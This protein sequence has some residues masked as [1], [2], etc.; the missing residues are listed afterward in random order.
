MQLS[1]LAASVV[2]TVTTVA[3]IASPASG[4][5]RADV[6]G[7][8]VATITDH[9]WVVALVDQAGH[10]FCGGTLVAPT[11]VV[12][13]AHCVLGRPT[14]DLVVVGGRTDL[15]QVTPGDAVSGVSAVSSP[16]G[17][18][19]PQRG[20]DIAT[21]TLATAFPY[22]P[23]SPVTDDSAD[24]PGT[25]GAVLGWGN[26]DA[27]PH[28]TTTVLHAVRVPVLAD[29]DCAALYDRYVSGGYD[30]HAMFCAGFTGQGVGAC[31]KDAGD[32]LVVDGRLA[33][34]VSWTIG[35]G[36]H[37]AFFTRIQSYTR[38]SSYPTG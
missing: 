36:A 21:L 28:D 13:T 1:R 38:V 18:V 30:S 8:E 7:G 17:F 34:I 14:A 26:L 5:T 16:A 12:T 31:A 27:D 37:P 3:A 15:G 19:T 25:V 32:P 2:L 11:A 24:Q 33:G 9:P 20:D 29:A 35:C 4:T 10:P 22:Q 23:L 6:A